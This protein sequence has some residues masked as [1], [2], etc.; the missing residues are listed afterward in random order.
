M[1]RNYHFFLFIDLFLLDLAFSV[2][3]FSTPPFIAAALTF[4]REGSV[5]DYFGLN[6]NFRCGE[7]KQKIE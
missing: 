2:G 1:V 7:K 4:H 6:F 5:E 3:I